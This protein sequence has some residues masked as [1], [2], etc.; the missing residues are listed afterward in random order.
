VKRLPV[1][2]TAIAILCPAAAVAQS[3]VTLERPGVQV[4]FSFDGR[5]NDFAGPDDGR[6]LR[7]WEWLG[8]DLRGTIVDPRLVRY[9]IGLRPGWRQTVSDGLLTEP[10]KNA[11]LLAWRAGVELLPSR[12]L[13][14]SLFTFRDRDVRQNRIGD[15]SQYDVTETSARLSYENRYFPVTARYRSRSSARVG[16]LTADDPLDAKA[17]RE[18]I[19]FQVLRVAAQNSRTRFLFER[20]SHEDRIAGVT[21]D[22]TAASLRHRVRWGKGS[23]I[24]SALEYL[25]YDGGADLRQLTWR[26][27]IHLQ[28]SW[29]VFSDYEFLL[30]SFRDGGFPGTERLALIAATVRPVGRL[31]SRTRASWY[32]R[33]FNTSSTG[34]TRL[35]ERL[36]YSTR[37]P[38]GGRMTA[39]ASLE[40][41]RF[42]FE[43]GEVAN[44]ISVVDERYEVDAAGRVILMNVGVDAVSVR[45]KNADGSLIYQLGFDYQLLD[46]P[47]LTEIL[48]IPTGRIVAGD[49][50]QVDYR[51]QALPESRSSNLVGGF[52]MTAGM[53]GFELF[54]R[55]IRTAARSESP[56]AADIPSV[57]SR[58]APEDLNETVVGL[59]MSQ[60]MWRTQMEFGFKWSDRQRRDYAQRS[61]E[62]FGGLTLQPRR[63]VAIGVSATGIWG[64]STNGLFRSVSGGTTIRWMPLPSLLCHGNLTLWRRAVGDELQTFFGGG[65]GVSWQPGLLEIQLQFTHDRLQGA[66]SQTIDRL[67]AYISRSF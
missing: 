7:Y 22:K 35:L 29:S 2:V 48:V 24:R 49:T 32:S 4:G 27:L 63:D 40:Y 5:W 16:S 21:L 9:S 56:G 51:Y 25:D 38:F 10:E 59:R 13:S 54:T 19:R 52:E 41:N 8:L 58:F 50:L 67:A 44:W 3:A 55:G 53:A 18:D 36:S 11:S 28:H 14:L 62:L 17:P 66:S 34:T 30:R 60:V 6:T 20:Q 65:A 33:G 64:R 26:E 47:P 1:V 23:S 12:P 31:Q 46:D 57:Q 45:V 39:S 15:R 43:P 37:L 42:S 61:T